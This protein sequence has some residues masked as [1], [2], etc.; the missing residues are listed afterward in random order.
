MGDRQL[1]TDS[2]TNFLS[3]GLKRQTGTVPALT[4]IAGTGLRTA[5]TNQQ[6]IQA[7]LG[8]LAWPATIKKERPS[9][10]LET[11]LNAG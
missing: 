7:F 10:D 2:K 11:D 6:L 8:P 4:A 3:Q 5:V 9:M 1:I